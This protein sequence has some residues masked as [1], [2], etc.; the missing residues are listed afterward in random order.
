[1]LVITRA[2]QS[3]FQGR[4]SNYLAPPLVTVGSP[5][6]DHGLPPGRPSGTPHKKF[7]EE[8]INLK[9]TFCLK[10]LILSPR[11]PRNFSN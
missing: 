7:S 9:C 4:G 2:D 6:T 3:I 8:K 1:M 11:N 5:L 10:N